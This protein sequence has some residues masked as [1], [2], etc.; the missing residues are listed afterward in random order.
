MLPSSAPYLA[1]IDGD[2]QHDECVFV[3]M[4][5]HL[6]QEGYDI[7]IGSRYAASGSIGD[8]AGIRAWTSRWVT[9]LNRPLVPIGL[10]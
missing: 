8:G 10:T 1:V 3:D 2:L 4:L 6:K 7:V 5:R 9:L